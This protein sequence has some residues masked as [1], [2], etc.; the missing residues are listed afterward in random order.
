[1]GYARHIGRVGALAVTL[2][3][4]V[5]LASA[6]GVA[7][8]EPSST[9][10]T[11]DSSTSSASPSGTSPSRDS[12]AKDRTEKRD[13][14]KPRDAAADGGDDGDSDDRTTADTES[15]DGD[16]DEES[17]S[18]AG[19]E[20][21]RGSDR[22]TSKRSAVTLDA[23][24]ADDSSDAD[25]PATVD[26]ADF[27]AATTTALTT[28]EATSIE[29]ATVDATP[30][31]VASA[32]TPP[33]SAKR[34]TIVSVVPVAESA[35]LPPLAD[36]A[37]ETPPIQAPVMLAALAAVRD[38][39]ER[40]TLRRNATAVPQAAALIV[41]PSPN[42]LVIGVDGTNLSRVLDDPANANFFELMQGGTT[43]AA[44]I[45]GHTTIS[46][47]SWS[48]I[49]TGA[50]G[51][52]TGV[53]NNVF[54][55]WTYDNWPTVFNQLEAANSA[56]QTTAIANWDVIS[57]IAAAGA[58]PADLVRNI[59]QIEGD[60]NWLLTDDAVGDATEAAI[61]A[62]SAAVPN[63]VFSYFVGVDENGHMYGGASPE[64][65]AALNNFDRNLGEILDA[66]NAWE[67]LTGEQWT[68]I[69]V[70]DHGHQPQQG[71]G[72]GF[73]SPD[74]TSTFV[75]ANN[76]LIFAESGIN[77]QY[78]IV[79]VTPTVL[80]LFGGPPPV[81]ADG[82]SLTELGD[83]TVFP[84]N[85]DEALRVAL[86]DAIG[87]YGYP[88][89]GTQ[90]ALGLRT[91]VTSVPYFVF[92][93]TNQLTSALQGIADQDIFLISF[94]AR[95]A[96]LPVQFIGDLAYVATNFAAQI[97]AG[98]TGVTGASIFPLWPPA[99]PSFPTTPEEATTLDALLACGDSRGAGAAMVCGDGDIA[100]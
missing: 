49:L 34:P 36:P 77:L 38:E 54:T 87:M 52:T 23:G 5:A 4:G 32:P 46:N 17:R 48:S 66:V 13:S 80:D 64:Y 97:V 99:A 73:Q 82:V 58:D 37:P 60:T 45:V 69:M 78:Q 86:Q 91:I 19:D 25:A 42:V 27:A 95:L 55:P 53:I 1:M 70:T 10:S 41:D 15:E 51:E 92:G 3:V 7:S 59:Y 50:W 47:P 11:S 29:V 2:G 72:H 89:I 40:N 30:I 84:I 43:A 57:A 74:E 100:V 31:P 67:T 94:L 9:S 16:G 26:T 20:A 56:I 83:S 68:I 98:L 8:A 93:I 14:S 18:A 65:A 75:I 35:V 79:D 22:R 85:D 96:I 90:L 62:A 71:L 21:D 88:D 61:A 33:V 81:D 6:P 28:T 12:A 24:L 76:P 44:S 39:L 63:F